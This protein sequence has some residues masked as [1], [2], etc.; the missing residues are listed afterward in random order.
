MSGLQGSRLSIH[1][2]P[3]ETFHM[4]TYT[5]S[6][7]IHAPYICSSSSSHLHRSGDNFATALLVMP[8]N[9]PCIPIAHTGGFVTGDQVGHEAR[10]NHR[11][12]ADL[13]TRS[14]TNKL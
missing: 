11:R 4:Q 10:T 2:P 7:R 8:A 14:H 1:V 13:L 6:S 5:A 9:K 3:T 12:R